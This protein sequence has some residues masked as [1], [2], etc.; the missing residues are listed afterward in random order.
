MVDD[1]EPKDGFGIGKALALLGQIGLSIALPLVFFVW[2]S[3]QAARYYGGGTAFLAG[4]V[5]LG[6]AVG[7]LQ[8]YRIMLRETEQGGSK[9]GSR[10]K[11]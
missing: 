7:F 2:L 6:L 1:V 4:A 3:Q 9:S 10:N 11:D 5:I 8:V